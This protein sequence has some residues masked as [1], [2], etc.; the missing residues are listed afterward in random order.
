MN[1]GH[2]IWNE[3]QRMSVYDTSAISVLATVIPPPLPLQ[4]PECVY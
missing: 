1:S 3:V 2:Q 4:S